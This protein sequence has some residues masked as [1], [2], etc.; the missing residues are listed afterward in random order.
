MAFGL[1]SLQRQVK[2]FLIDYMAKH[3]GLAPTRA[4][5]AAG[6]GY[7]ST[8][9]VNRIIAALEDRGHIETLTA[10]HRAIRVVE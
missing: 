1:N 4:E 6:C 7:S 3:D 8:S 2:Q 10:R 9:K 5:I